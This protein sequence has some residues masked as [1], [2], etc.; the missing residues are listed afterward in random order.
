MEHCHHCPLKDSNAVCLAVQRSHK[1]LCDLVSAGNED[2]TR[3]ILEDAETQAPGLQIDPG[4]THPVRLGKVMPCPLDA[5]LAGTRRPPGMVKELVVSRYKEDVS[6]VNSCPFPATVY[7]KGGAPVNLGGHVTRLHLANRGREAGT[8]LD[9]ICTYYE[10]LAETTFFVQGQP[11]ADHLWERLG[12]EYDDVCSLTWEY[13]PVHPSNEIKAL[14]LVQEK[15]GYPVR[16]GIADPPGSTPWVFSVWPTFFSC[17]Q[18][19]PWW[20]PYGAE[21]AVPRRRIKARPLADWV[22]LRDL[23]NNADNSRHDADSAN[24]WAIE[25]CWLYLLADPVAFPLNKGVAPRTTPRTKAAS[26]MGMVKKGGC[27]CGGG[28]ITSRT[29]ASKGR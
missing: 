7:D 18:P 12:L 3:L 6:W 22:Y 9:H 8:W 17:S 25:F 27:G 24:A 21:L 29:N 23:V 2:Y 4:E 13:S 1:R 26:A 28:I 15:G 16:Y 14:D 5:D 11:H 10:D 20:F 19:A